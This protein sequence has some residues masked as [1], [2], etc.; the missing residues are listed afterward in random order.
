MQLSRKALSAILRPGIASLLPVLALALLFACMPPDGQERSPWLLFVGKFH[1]LTIHFPIALLYLVPLLELIGRYE[2]FHH[3]RAAVEFILVLAM[4]SSLFAAALGW[5]LARSGGYSG[6]IVTQHMWGG[7]LTA[8]GCWL[9]W[10]LRS[11]MSG[12]QGTI[13]YIIALAVTVGVVSWTGYRGGQLTQGENH[14]TDG[15]PAS[16]R[17]MLGLGNKAGAASPS[18]PP[19]DRT[20]FYGG[21]VEPILASNCYSCHGPDKQRGELRLDSFNALMRGGKHGLEIKPGD[22]KASE[23]IRRINLPQTD[24]NAMPPQGK[25]RLTS[26]EIDTLVA[27]INAGASEISPLNAVKGAP[28]TVVAAPAEVT[29]PDYYDPAAVEKLRAPHAT[30]VAALQKRYPNLVQYQSRTSAMLSINAEL[31]GEKFSDN[32][33]TALKPVLDQIITADFSG[34][35]ITD[36]SAAAIA[37]MKHLQQLRL[38]HTKITDAAVQQLHNLAELNSINLLGT[39]VTA[40]SIPSLSTMPKIQ[41]AY[42]AE[43]HITPAIATTPALK[44]EFVF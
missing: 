13:A 18:A 42:V 34:T 31:I 26:S 9:C 37:T 21:R 28:T 6:H 15:M 2:R 16:L 22:A 36:R 40:A 38:A 1:L 32:D 19:I 7:L 8:A 3:L 20:T 4:L 5:S 11:R 27:W 12:G 44:Q 25:R 41:H 17:S 35:S 33:V 29:F 24:D 30:E 14:L 10:L 39:S 23:L 43:T